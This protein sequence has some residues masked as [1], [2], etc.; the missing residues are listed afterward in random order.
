MKR[1]L[2]QWEPL[3]LFF[4]STYI[5]HRVLA[6]EEI[7]ND[8]NDKAINLFY[9][10]LEWVLPKFVDMNKYFQSEKVVIK[11]LHTQMVNIYKDLLLAYM[12]PQYVRQTDVDEIDPE[13]NAKFVS[14]NNIFLG[15]DVISKIN[16]LSNE[17]KQ[18]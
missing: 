14:L 3:R 16:H 10:F 13:N 1:I 2:E 6:S 8:L 15:I 5:E 12:D 4:T 11:K 18:N 7:Y 9:L 17:I